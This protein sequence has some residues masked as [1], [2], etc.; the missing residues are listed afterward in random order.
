MAELLK[1][2]YPRYVELHNYRYRNSIAFKVDNWTTLNRKVLSKIGM[3]LSKNVIT[4][5][6]YSKPGV[7]ESV[8]ADLRA[9]ILKDC[10]ADR[11]SL[12]FEYDDNGKG[13]KSLHLRDKFDN[14]SLFAFRKIYSLPFLTAVKHRVLLCGEISSNLNHIILTYNNR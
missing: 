8:L 13:A 9:K 7:I 1:R 2:Y 12:Y 6:V 4:G 10:N 14:S 5:L 11:D 3:K